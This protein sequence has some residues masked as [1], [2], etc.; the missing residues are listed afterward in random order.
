MTKGK[1]ALL[2]EGYE[3]NQIKYGTMHAKVYQLG[4]KCPCHVEAIENAEQFSWC[5]RTGRGNFV[6]FCYCGDLLKDTV[7]LPELSKG[8]NYR[9]PSVDQGDEIPTT[10]VGKTRVSYLDEK[11][12]RKRKILKEKGKQKRFTVDSA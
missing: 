5:A 9:E 8:A 11:F 4:Y 7:F 12:T 10:Y 6:A 2:D 3:K 1:W